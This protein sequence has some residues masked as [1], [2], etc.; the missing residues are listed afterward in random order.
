MQPWGGAYKTFDFDLSL[1]LSLF[2]QSV[3]ASAYKWLESMLKLQIGQI[4][5]TYLELDHE[6]DLRLK[7][8]YKHRP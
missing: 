1:F 3:Q 6:L 8:F 5:T 2:E 4:L 7:K